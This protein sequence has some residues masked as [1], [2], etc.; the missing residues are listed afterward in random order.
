MA[1]TSQTGD[2]FWKSLAIAELGMR[3]NWDEES[4]RDDSGFVSRVKENLSFEMYRVVSVIG[5]ALAGDRHYQGSKGNRGGVLT[6]LSSMLPLYL[7][8]ETS[9][10]YNLFYSRLRYSKEPNS[11]VEQVKYI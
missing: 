3:E 7:Q 6:S 9:Y 2:L 11:S 1:G 8:F 10:F 4:S 5:G